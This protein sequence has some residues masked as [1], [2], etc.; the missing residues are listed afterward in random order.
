MLYRV[1]LSLAVYIGFPRAVKPIEKNFV[2]A[3]SGCIACVL[4]PWGS[5]STRAVFL[6]AL[7]QPATLAGA[8][9]RI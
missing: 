3:A 8:P 4:P 2:R 5:G 6:G 7:D 9:L 1:V